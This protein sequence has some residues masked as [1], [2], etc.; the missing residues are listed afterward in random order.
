MTA[1]E[2]RLPREQFMRIHRS[3]IVNLAALQEL[4]RAG[5]GE[6]LVAL[7]NGRHLPVGPTYTPLIR[8]AL[9]SDQL[10]RFGGSLG[11]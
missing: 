4:Y 10:P 1:M 7:R 8:A 6:Y 9:S 3:F 11:L 2:M 5:D